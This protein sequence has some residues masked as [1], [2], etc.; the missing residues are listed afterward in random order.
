M[1]ALFRRAGFDADGGKV[2]VGA[3]VKVF[4]GPEARK[5]LAWRATGQLQRGDAVRQS[6]LDVGIT[7]E[8][9]QQTLDAVAKW[10]EMED[11]WYVSPQCEMLAWK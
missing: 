1:P 2:R 10:A 4:S 3:G 5:W 11:A 7:E 9:I 8:E 6:W